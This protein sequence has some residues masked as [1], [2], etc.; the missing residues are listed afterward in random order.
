MHHIHEVWSERLYVLFLI[1]RQLGFYGNTSDPP[2][3]ILHT[4][5]RNK[6]N[7]AHEEIFNE[8]MEREAS[9]G[10][11]TIQRTKTH[12]YIETAAAKTVMAMPANNRLSKN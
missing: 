1:K 10:Q 4:H 12:T 11:S 9:Y 6:L 5:T 8:E 7:L 3:G 2:G